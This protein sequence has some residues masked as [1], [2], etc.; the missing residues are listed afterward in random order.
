MGPGCGA[1]RESGPSSAQTEAE[2]ERGGRA[3]SGEEQALPPRPP[4]PQPTCPARAPPRRRSLARSG[5]ESWPLPPPSSSPAAS[6]F[7]LLLPLPAGG[8]CGL[9]PSAPSRER[10]PARP[11]AARPGGENARGPR[12]APGRGG[13]PGRSAA[14]RSPLEVNSEA[15]AARPPAPSQPAPPA[16]STHCQ[17]RTCAACAGWKTV[18]APPGAAQ[19]L[20]PPLHF[21]QTC[22]SKVS[23]ASW[24]QRPFKVDWGSRGWP[25]LASGL[26]SGRGQSP[27]SP[28][29]PLA[30]GWGRR[31]GVCV[32]VCERVC[33]GG[34]GAAFAP[35]RVALPLCP[36]AEGPLSGLGAGERG[37]ILSQLDRGEGKAG[38]AVLS[39]LPTVLQL[40]RPPFSAQTCPWSLTQSHGACHSLFL[41]TSPDSSRPSD[42]CEPHQITS[43]WEPLS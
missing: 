36:K 34:G 21:A 5:L 11:P 13:T 27:V 18:D 1:R 6:S 28:S 29:S 33:R 15:P 42:P 39:S 41:R 37:P 10:P 4:P 40:C 31:K 20:G 30:R 24:R 26:H 23:A 22:F 43:I 16:A 2:R 3:G 14:S 32:S 17:A 25:P 12:G 7:P 35:P 9:R 19:R 8:G 38:K